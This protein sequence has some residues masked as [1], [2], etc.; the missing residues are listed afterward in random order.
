MLAT[1]T[2]GEIPTITLNTFKGGV[3]KTTT[4]YN[5]GWFFA[6]KGLRTLMV[7]LDP[8]CNLTQIFLESM[9]QDNEET[10]TRKQE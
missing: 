6:S 8:Q 5:L 10:T 3:S 9:I 1:A 2:T 7:D 4:T